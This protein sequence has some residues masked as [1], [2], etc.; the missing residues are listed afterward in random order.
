[1]AISGTLT[2]SNETTDYGYFSLADIA[3]M[4]VIETHRTRIDDIFS[5]PKDII[6][7]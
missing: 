1:V 2:T 3:D 7:K 5:F 4:D 6:L